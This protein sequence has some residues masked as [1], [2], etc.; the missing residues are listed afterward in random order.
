MS[1]ISNVLY[2]ILMLDMDGSKRNQMFLTK[3]CW[4][5]IWS[6]KARLAEKYC[7]Q[8]SNRLQNKIKTFSQIRKVFILDSKHKKRINFSPKKEIAFNIRVHLVQSYIAYTFHTVL[9]F[10]PVENLGDILLGNEEALGLCCA[11]IWRLV[12]AET[13][14]HSCNGPAPV[15]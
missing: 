8:Y 1:N 4:D 12:S 15:Y 5:E 7:L 6:M 2:S 9:W 13:F 10:L 11:V 3:K 14:F